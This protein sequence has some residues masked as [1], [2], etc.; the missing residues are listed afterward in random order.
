MT[1]LWGKFCDIQLFSNYALQWDKQINWK[2]LG[3]K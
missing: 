3:N 1:S 2:H